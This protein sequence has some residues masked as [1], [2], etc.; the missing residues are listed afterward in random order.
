ME[1]KWELKRISE[2]FYLLVDASDSSEKD[3]L[4]KRFKKDP[5]A[6]NDLYTTIEKIAQHG[7]T[8]GVEY[9]FRAAYFDTIKGSIIGLIE[10]RRFRDV[11]RVL[12][13]HDKKRKKL[14]MLDAFKAHEHVST[15]KAAQ[16]VEPKAEIAKK[17]LEKDG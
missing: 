9:A 13:Y 14:V 17:I 7:Y 15:L 3:I 2:F 11:W 12:T 8:K 4:Q 16:R 6:L 5:N 1:E 10:I